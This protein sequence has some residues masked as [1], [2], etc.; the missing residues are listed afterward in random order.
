MDP[1]QIGNYCYKRMYLWLQYSKSS[2]HFTEIVI[3]VFYPND[4]QADGLVMFNHGFLI[5][6]DLSYYPKLI[7]SKLMG[8][9]TPLYE[10]N[11]SFYYNYSDAAIKNHWALAFVT[12][13]HQ[14]VDIM[15][16]TDFGGN[17]RVGQEAYAAASYLV[18]YGATY[19]Y[20]DPGQV[21]ASRFLNVQ[22]ATS[23]NFMQNRVIFAGHSVG[24]AHAQVAAT[25][26][27]NIRRMGKE[28]R[29]PFDPVFF[30]REVVPGS[31]PAMSL[32]SS[33][34]RATPVG[35]LQLSPVDNKIPFLFTGMEAY[36]KQ[37]AT[38]PLPNLMVTGQCDSA[39]LKSSTPPS[40]IDEQDR[41]SS[42]FAQMAYSSSG[43]WASTCMVEKGSHCGY[44]RHGNDLCS[45]A[46]KDSKKCEG[47]SSVTPYAANQ[48]E[49]AFTN[50]LLDRFIKSTTPFPGSLAAWKS[51]D[52]VQ[53]LNS[54]NPAGTAITL[55]KFT[56]GYL[57]FA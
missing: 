26:F 9:D 49:F 33:E 52:F 5:G 20:D 17:P 10:I 51:G 21:A 30:N 19:K 44:L 15:P 8:Q 22:D 3:E 1:I 53:W 50:E 18:R 24:G 32:W 39:T 57:H 54:S 40:W 36:R 14:Q 45:Q 12:S 48:E 56:D 7:Y 55:K 13:S 35:L 11:P 29:M 16:W 31:T 25:G 27:D 6:V 46:D 23:G 38:L 2:P 28:Q 43:S 4:R 34:Q 37:L 41:S 47:C 42:Q